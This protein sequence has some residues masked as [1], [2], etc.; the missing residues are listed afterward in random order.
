M[1]EMSSLETAYVAGILLLSLV[2]PLLMSIC[3]PRGAGAKRSCMKTVWI[4]QALLA[5][6]GLAV[7]ASAAVAPYA[8][9]FGVMSCLCSTLV[10]LRQ[11]RAERRA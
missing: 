6:A 5:V 10:L 11:F 4:E 2:L 1:R 9:A 8:A 3:G 7:F